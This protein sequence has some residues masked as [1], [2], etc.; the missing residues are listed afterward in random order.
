ME[1]LTNGSVKS[2][3]RIILYR[4]R[5][6]AFLKLSARFFLALK[7]PLESSQFAYA[8]CGPQA[9]ALLSICCARRR[10]DANVFGASNCTISAFFLIKFISEFTSSNFFLFAIRTG[11]LKRAEE[12]LFVF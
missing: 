4:G 9:F 11:Q 5:P 1:I 10:A 2:I 8:I 3:A 7:W 12:G 6:S